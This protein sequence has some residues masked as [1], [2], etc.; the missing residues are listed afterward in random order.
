MP[1]KKSTGASKKAAPAVH[2]SYRDMIKDAIVNLKERN[3]SSRQAIKK[4]V[5]ANND[6]HVMSPGIFDAQFNKAIKGGVEKGEFTQPK[7]PSGPVKLAKKEP[8]VKAPAKPAAKPATKPAA[9]PAAKTTKATKATTKKAAPKKA[10]KT[11][12]NKKTT[13]KATTKKTATKA[14]AKPKANSGKARKTPV[15][16][17]AIVEQPKVLGK[18]KSGRVTKT[19][20]PPPPARTGRAAPK[21]RVAKK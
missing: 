4:Y 1:P 14:A 12:G 20:A 18:T 8:G 10:A 16:A 5:S 2:T 3:G 11:A 19:T 6:I 17:P 9:K 7:G 15:S 21:K 13:T